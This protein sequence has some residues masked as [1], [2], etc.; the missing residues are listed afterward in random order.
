MRI[1]QVTARYHPYIGG[2]ETVVRQY[3]THML[4]NGH[5]VE[6][7]T[8]DQDG[9]LLEE[10]NVDGVRI[11]RFR[12]DSPLRSSRK[13]ASYLRKEAHRFDIIH[14]HSLH[15]L[16]PYLTLRSIERSENR[17]LVVMGHYSG[18]GS[19]FISNQLLTLYR[20]LIKKYWLSV[21]AA[22]C[23]SH[24]EATMLKR[25][26]RVPGEKVV[27]IANGVELDQ[28]R[29]S[30]SFPG[31]GK[32]ILI[33]SRIEKY[34]NIQLAVEAMKHLDRDVRLFI[35][36]DGPYR[37]EVEKLIDRYELGD[38]VRIIGFIPHE[39]VYRWYKS[40]D[41]II[42]LSSLE[43]FGLTV[44]EGLAAGK[45]VLVNDETSLHELAR[46]L[47]GVRACRATSLDPARLAAEIEKALSLKFDP[48][49]L[50]AYRWDEITD[51]ILSCYKSIL[52]HKILHCL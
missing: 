31:Q 43:C 34:K 39:E 16:I 12:E 13:L 33:A 37:S 36:G 49:D 15:T 5:D 40:C 4:R 47:P 41:L 26:F 28:I 32:R 21:D 52:D 8:L 7:L 48:P 14:A 10:E 51:K 38:R 23:V 1:A 50:D 17:G 45:P 24:F 19:T 3:A 35:L 18:K 25:H 27:V 44:L 9:S 2:V 46:T 20:H 11:K 22:I 30:T 42:N 6:V 29:S